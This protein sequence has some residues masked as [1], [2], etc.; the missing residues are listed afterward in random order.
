MSELLRRGLRAGAPT[1][2]TARQRAIL[3]YMLEYREK[4]GAPPSMREIADHFD[5]ASLNGVSDHLKALE[6][7][8]YVRHYHGRS[9]GW[10]PA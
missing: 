2:L 7:K 10:V 8:G 4:H 5:Y 3:E 1:S 6:R 9:R